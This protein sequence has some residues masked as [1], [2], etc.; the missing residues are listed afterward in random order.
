MQTHCNSTLASYIYLMKR[1]C[2]LFILLTSLI[3][4]TGLYSC[5][6]ESIITSKDALL[7]LSEDT[8]HF[9]TVFT[10]MGS[11]T[12]FFKI[13]NSNSQKLILSNVQLMGGTSSFFKINI[14]GS[15]GTIFNNVEI[16]PNDSLY[17]FVTVTIN[18][19]AAALPFVV[20]DSISINFNGNKKYL[21]LEAFG[22]NARFLRNK[23][24]A[25]DTTFTNTLPI[26]IL[27]NLTVNEGRKL[28]INEG[29]KIYLNAN[30][31]IIVNGT[32]QA[33]GKKFDSTKIVF[34]G[35][36]LDEPYKGFPGSW[37]G[38]YFNEKSVNNVLQYC[39]I[40]NAYQGVILQSPATNASPKV[41]LQEC[42]FDNIYDVAIGAVNSSIAARNCLVSNCGNNL[43]IL[44]GGNYNFNHC[45]FVSIG[46][47]YVEHKNPAAFV[48]NSNSTN[49]TN[50][51]NCSFTN[52]IIYGEGGLVDDEITISRNVATAFNLS[53][54]NVLYKV[55]ND[56]SP[57]V[58]T[59]SNSL[60][61]IL[62]LFDSIDNGKRVYNF[63]LKPTSPCINKGITT[64]LNIDLDGNPR[65][66]GILP[67]LGCYE[68]Q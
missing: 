49:Q 46:N 60:K 36:R 15:S 4:F 21:Q 37:P 33:I 30:A 56:I 12:Q 52:S 55:K 14:D 28:T 38:I 27:G 68:K 13:F 3:G 57:S 8:L 9:D 31:P 17:G 11:T 53:L 6:K 40:K 64:A 54:T 41:I 7:R 50:V 2:F 10:T 39:V 63:R 24:I 67:D 5:Q 62:P 34:Q 59:I 48:S 1:I 23:V 43:F 26:V 19:N 58:A 45:T 22:Q 65:P 44:S 42:I 47:S 20:R 66:V 61:N 16:A 32:L 35:N 51:L 25:T 29:T 18:P